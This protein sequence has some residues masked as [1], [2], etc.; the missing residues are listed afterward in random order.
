M[1]RPFDEVRYRALLEGLEVVEIPLSTLERTLRIDA[2]FFQLWH[3]RVAKKLAIRNTQIVTEIAAVSDGNHFTIS[4]EFVEQGFPY[5][6]GQD[7]VGHFFIEKSTPTFITD[8]AFKKPF[9]TRSHLKRGDVLLSIIGTIGEA[10]LV[11][12]ETPATCSCKLAILRPHNI[13]PE[14]LAVFLRSHYGRSQVERF[15]RGAVQMGLLLED[16]DQIKVAR[17][18]PNFEAAIAAIVISAKNS[19]E[20]AV[21]KA[22][23]AEQTLLRALGLENWQ[24][25]E[26]LTYIRSSQD[27]FAAGRLDAEHFKPK[28]ANLEMHIQATGHF[29]SLGSLL[30]INERGIQPE[31]REVGLP[32]VNSKHVT[33]SEV[34][35]NDGNRLAL[36]NSRTLKIKKGDVLI[37]GTGVGTIGR[38]APYLHDQEAIPDNHVTV[39]RPKKHSIDPVYL[40]VF[41]NSLAGQYQV[42]KWLRGSSGQIE[43]Y[44]ND[45]A[46]FLVWIAPDEIQRSIK[47]A[48]HGAFAEKQNAITLLDAAKRAVEIA[49]ESS[50]A[51]ALEFLDAATEGDLTCT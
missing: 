8:R 1:S 28:Y 11:S 27:A 23:Q 36:A 51:A 3:L 44:P 12:D 32:V 41:L 49:I 21:K 24:P 20:A 9:M 25:P 14:Y 19:L 39:L 22:T 4:E 35:L 40:S 26:P 6:R 38:T 30:V 46:Q 37:N 50:E 5:Y 48:I 15:T 45:I 7:V 34:R 16:M 42:S 18:T 17:L 43:L 29:V 33:N 2:E 47:S 13:A 31:Y 10:S